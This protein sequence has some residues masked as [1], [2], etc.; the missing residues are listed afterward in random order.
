MLDLVAELLELLALLGLAEEGAEVRWTEEVLA[1]EGAEVRWAEAKEVLV[2]LMALVWARRAALLGLISP[3]A[4]DVYHYYQYS[5]H[6]P[7]E[8][9]S[10]II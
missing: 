2:G 9:P 7:Q 3:N 4:D 10:K 1:E 8:G 5:K 6:I